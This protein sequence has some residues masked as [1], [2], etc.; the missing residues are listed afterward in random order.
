MSS[1]NIT[2]EGVNL[3]LCTAGAVRDEAKGEPAEGQQ[4]GGRAPQ[5][6]LS[7]ITTF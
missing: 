2:V 3:A 4:D 7:G 6:N 1:K 5:P